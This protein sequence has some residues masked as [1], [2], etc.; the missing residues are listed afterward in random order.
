V[1]GDQPRLG[2]PAIRQIV[3]AWPID[4]QRSIIIPTYQGKRG[5][6]TL[7]AWK[8]VAGIR[9]LP[10]DQGLNVYIRQHAKETLELAVDSE[11]IVVDLDT[12]EDYERLQ[13]EGPETPI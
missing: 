1:P 8:H 10:P 7:L 6:P 5:H 4:G 11:G 3:R 12:P 9:G 13:Q 2:P